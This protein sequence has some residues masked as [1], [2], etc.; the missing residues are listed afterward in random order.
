[1]RS[2]LGALPTPRRATAL[3]T[4]I[5][6]GQIPPVKDMERNQLGQFM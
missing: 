3:L 1:M 2:P 6:K 4:R 5:P